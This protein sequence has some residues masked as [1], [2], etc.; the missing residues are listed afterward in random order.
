MT[1]EGSFLSNYWPFVKFQTLKFDGPMPSFSEN[2]V[3][4]NTTEKYYQYQKF[5]LVDPEYAVVLLGIEDPSDV[6]TA[7]GQDA[8]S[9]WRK[10]QDA[11][12]GKKTTLV[13]AK[14]HFKKT[15][16]GFDRDAVML[17]GLRLKFQDPVL[18]QALL[19]TGDRPLSELGRRPTEYWTH[20]GANKLGELLMQVRSELRTE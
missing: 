11:A 3:W 8:Y 9:R 15:I 20:C 10:E 16:T 12:S 4:F 18:R 1:K 2:G 5:M 17:Q 7:A 14:D 19:D 13:A 6:K